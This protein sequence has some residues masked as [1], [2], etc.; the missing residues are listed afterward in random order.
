LL[1]HSG[2]MKRRLPD[3]EVIE[4]ANAADAVTTMSDEDCVIDYL[5]KTNRS[6]L[7][8]FSHKPSSGYS[9]N[10]DK[11]QLALTRLVIQ[12]VS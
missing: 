11:T 1:I 2:E 9:C 8:I 6:I 7:L 5:L 4:V 3:N 10:A 12:M